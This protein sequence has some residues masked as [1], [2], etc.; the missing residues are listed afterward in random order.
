MKRYFLFIFLALNAILVHGADNCGSTPIK[1]LT[2]EAD[3][4]NGSA[5]ANTLH[6]E[7]TGS[8]CSS[9]DYA[10]LKNDQPSYAS[11]LSTLLSA[12]ASGK[13]VTVIVK[14]AGGLGPNSREID[15][16]ILP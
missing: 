15:Y 13:N 14:S 11:I 1:N 3:R 10:Y 8:S 6:I 4:E 9:I 16:I 2:I 7:I 12:H 5:W